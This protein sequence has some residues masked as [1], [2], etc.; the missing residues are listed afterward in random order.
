MRE[1]K[2]RIR[3]ITG[4]QCLKTRELWESVFS[5]DSAEFTE[6]YYRHKMVENIGYVWGEAPYEAMLFLTPY[7]VMIGESRE[8]LSYIVGVATRPEY[9]H[10]GR[11]RS[12]LL[13]ALREER[14]GGKP[15]VF[16]MPADPAIYTPFGF[17]YIYDRPEWEAAHPGW[18]EKVLR[19]LCGT[20]EKIPVPVGEDF[21]E[22]Q[23][24]S[25]MPERERERLCS[26]V[27]E[28]ANEELFRTKQIY[29]SRDTAYY[30]RQI[31]ESRAQRGD[32][33]VWLKGEEP[34]GFFLYA[35][36][37]EEAYFQDIILSKELWE[38][39]AFFR[40]KGQ[41]PIIMGR[42]LDPGAMLARIKG[43]ESWQLRLH[44]EDDFLTE[45]SGDY[46]WESSPE[47]GRLLKASSGKGLLQAAEQRNELALSTEELTELVFGRARPAQWLREGRISEETAEKLEMLS[48][49]REIS[50]NEIV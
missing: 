43:R 31:K 48:P 18:E 40:V 49:L 16:L 14:D 12:L 15:F 33:F 42:I 45:N 22:L 11:M 4:S 2:S 5:E 21:L 29:V 36:E 50:L 32:V 9:R 1:A 47:G 34:E 8:L 26:R 41:K 44:L 46:L 7:S 35:A 20:G 6:Y 10:R 25:G 24:L 38:K 28:F 37:E 3:R 13:N 17:R 23:S 19:P 30:L 27:A 39:G